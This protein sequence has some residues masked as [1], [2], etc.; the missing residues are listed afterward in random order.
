MKKYDYE[1]CIRQP[2]GFFQAEIGSVKTKD[3][4]EAI[5]ELLIKK[6]WLFKNSIGHETITIIMKRDV[7]ETVLEKMKQPLE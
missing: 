7:T 1:V 5:H 6:E 4:I 3:L 2:S